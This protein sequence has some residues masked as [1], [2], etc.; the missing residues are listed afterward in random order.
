MNSQYLKTEVMAKQ[1]SIERP[2]SNVST[3]KSMRR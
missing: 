1:F 2:K 3:R